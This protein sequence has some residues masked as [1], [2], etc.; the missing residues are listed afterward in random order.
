MTTASSADTQ[1]STAY[2]VRPLSVVPE[3]DEF[4]VGDVERGEFVLLPEVGVQ[5][6]RLLQAG[7][8]PAETG[9]AIGPAGAVPGFLTG[10]EKLGFIAPVPGQKREAGLEA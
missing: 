6:L 1:P 3:G 10:M 4:L 2:R 7:N 5:V 8:T 9:S